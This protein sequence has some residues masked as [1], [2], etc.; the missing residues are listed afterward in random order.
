MN[1]PV[2]YYQTAE[3]L[4]ILFFDAYKVAL[5]VC[6]IFAELLTYPKGFLAKKLY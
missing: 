5:T 6:A 1:G 2:S 4:C 3:I